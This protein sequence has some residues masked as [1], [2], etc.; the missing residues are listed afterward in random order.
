LTPPG[1]KVFDLAMILFQQHDDIRHSPALRRCV[2]RVAGDGGAARARRVRAIGVS[3]FFADRVM[4]FLMHHDVAPAVDQIETPASSTTATPTWT[5]EGAARSR[6]FGASDDARRPPTPQ[7]TKA[8]A[9]FLGPDLVEE[10]QV[11]LGVRGAAESQ[12]ARPERGRRLARGETPD[13]DLFGGRV[14]QSENGD[15][16]PGRWQCAIEFTS[17]LAA[18]DHLLEPGGDGVMGIVSDK[19]RVGNG[20][21]DQ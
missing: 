5:R 1:K 6:T 2:R 19:S 20:R 8:K 18:S 16:E 13:R 9:P 7:A 4:D 17:V 10:M 15:S 11:A 3:N 12:R 21:I 14:A